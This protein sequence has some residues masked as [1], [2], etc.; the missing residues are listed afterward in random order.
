M[1]KLSCV[2]IYVVYIV[3]IHYKG[4]SVFSANCLEPTLTSFFHF[5][6]F[7]YFLFVFGAFLLFC[8]VLHCQPPQYINN[9]LLHSGEKRL[10]KFSRSKSAP[11]MLSWSSAWTTRW[12]GEIIQIFTEIIQYT[13]ILKLYRYLLKTEIIAMSSLIS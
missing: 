11:W 9:L 5:V 3:Y 2:I 4:L 13:V 1:G 12:M 6:F 10:G 7:S 8:F